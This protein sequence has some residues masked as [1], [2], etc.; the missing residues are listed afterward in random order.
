VAAVV[1]YS[2]SVEK[3]VAV[4]FK[5]VTFLSIFIGEMKICINVV[6]VIRTGTGKV[7]QF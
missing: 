6:F 4:K 5:F 1:A 2:F 3:N 7:L